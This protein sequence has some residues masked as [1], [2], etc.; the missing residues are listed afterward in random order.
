MD[1]NIKRYLLTIIV[2]V[3]GFAAYFAIRPLCPQYW[4]FLMLGIV[5]LLGIAAAAI[6]KIK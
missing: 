3:A 5:L 2:F 6:H 4:M 1:N